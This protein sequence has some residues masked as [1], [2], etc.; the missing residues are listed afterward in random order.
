LANRLQRKL[1]AQQSRA[2]DFD[3]EE[4]TLDCR[5]CDPRR[6]RPDASLSFKHERDADSATRW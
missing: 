4:G 3:L 2:W 6:H 5:R 1:M